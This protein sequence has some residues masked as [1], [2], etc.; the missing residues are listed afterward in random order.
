V[1]TVSVQNFG[2]Q[3]S[4]LSAYCCKVFLNESHASPLLHSET[5]QWTWQ[6]MPLTAVINF[7]E[8]SQ[9]TSFSSLPLL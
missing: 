5:V 2:I 3:K 8:I 4:G 6:V 1:I 9:I 7:D